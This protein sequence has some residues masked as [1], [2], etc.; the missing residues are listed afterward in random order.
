MRRREGSGGGREAQAQDPVPLR[1]ALSQP[2]PAAAGHVP[3]RNGLI[4]RP[5][6]PP[7]TPGS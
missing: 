6:P 1:E 3:L 7:Q 4:T 5:S 2:P